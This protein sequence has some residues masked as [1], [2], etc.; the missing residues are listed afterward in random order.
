MSYIIKLTSFRAKP[1]GFR[2]I[3]VV[4]VFFSEC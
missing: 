1:A 4:T 2:S 3:D